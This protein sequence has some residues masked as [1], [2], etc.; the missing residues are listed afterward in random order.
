LKNTFIILILFLTLLTVVSA[1]D[2]SIRAIWVPCEGEYRALSSIE[3]IDKLLETAV[4][5]DIKIIFLQVY[6]GNRAWY[7]SS[8]ADPTPFK[9]I[10]KAAGQDTLAYFIEL[11]HKKNIEVHAWCNIFRVAKNDNAPLLKKYGEKAVTADN[12]GRNILTYQGYR[13]PAPDGKYYSYGNDGIW[14]EPGNSSVQKY[15]LKIISEII[16]KYPSIDGIHLDFV[17]YPFCTPVKLG[18]RFD[19]GID[20]G[21]GI[22]SIKRFI[23]SGGFNP[24]KTKLDREL[25]LQ[26]DNWRRKQ[27]TDFVRKS[28][29]LCKAKNKILSAAVIA[30]PDIAYNASF[31]DWIGWMEDGIIDILAPMIYTSD[32][33]ALKHAAKTATFFKNKTKVFVGFGAYLFNPN[34]QGNFELCWE[35]AKEANPDGIAIFSYDSIIKNKNQLEFLKGKKTEE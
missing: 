10:T 27:I 35:K 16:K 12:K 28:H 15:Q 22:S 18:S 1:Q 31:Q 11:A 5:L 29:T 4:E 19:K 13:I 14:L 2:S 24:L 9:N 34:F 7:D 6:R 30:W 8:I 25:C 33:I 17:R 20:Y 21:Y 3:K 23:H 26:W 32:Y